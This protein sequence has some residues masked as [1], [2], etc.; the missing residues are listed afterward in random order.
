MMDDLIVKYLAGETDTHEN[1]KVNDWLASSDENRRHFEQMTWVWEQSDTGTE[2]TIPIDEAWSR[3]NILKEKQHKTER[4][5]RGISWYY[6]AAA[7][8][9]V[10]IGAW[11]WFSISSNYKSVLL[12]S[13]AEV[14][15]VTLPD[16]SNVTLN[17]NSSLQYPSNFNSEAR[18][19][20]L[21]GE[22]YFV[23]VSD[24]DHPFIVKLDDVRITVLG[25]AFNARSRNNK[26]RIDVE[27]GRV[28]V[29]K[30]LS[31]AMLTSGE[32]L[33]INADSISFDPITASNRLYQH[34][35]LNAFICEDTPLGELFEVLSDAYGVQI[36]VADPAIY[37]LRISATFSD[38]P[39]SVIMDIIA[40]TFNID[41]TR[42]GSTYLLSEK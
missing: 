16:G 37:D 4:K 38:E 21:V 12:E 5:D 7:M 40:E 27:S 33:T 13:G 28:Q 19:V 10:A 25:T 41:I 3:F 2:A 17:A 24:S 30:D 31:S 39:I 6:A 20:T 23:I 14:T 32:S 9:V 15:A 8:V 34:Y 36:Q 26:T 22:G 11:Y 29:E 18:E 42:D 35:R 1:D